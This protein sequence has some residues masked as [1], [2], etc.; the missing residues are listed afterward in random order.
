M[1]D[2]A[3]ARRSPRPSLPQYFGAA[4]ARGAAL[5]E[6]MAWT[7]NHARGARRDDA[8]SSSDESP[9]PMDRMFGTEVGR[10]AANRIGNETRTLAA[11]QRLS[12]EI[13]A[14]ALRETRQVRKGDRLLAM[15]GRDDRAPVLLL[16]SSTLEDVDSSRVVSG[17][18]DLPLNVLMRGLERAA[19]SAGESAEAVAFRELL[20]GGREAVA[21]L[22]LVAQPEVVL[23][24]RPRMIRLCVPVPH[25]SV[26]ARGEL[27]TA[28][29]LCRDSDGELGVTACFH[30][31]GPAGTPVRVGDEESHVKRASEVQDIVFIPLGDPFP[32]APMHGIAG[33]R[34]DREPARA[35]T[36][37]FD[38]AVNQNRRT[39][40]F[41]TDTGLLRA[42]PT[43]M[44]KLQTDPDTD[45]GD[46]GCAL[47][48]D[49]D[50]VLGFAFERTAYD[51]YPQF[52]DWIWAANALRALDLAPFTGT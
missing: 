25:V 43:I 9:H 46:S 41:S 42:R 17:E 35:D 3:L 2:M 23:T 51:D 32:F 12:V 45:Q 30:G 5:D 20:E 24:R 8:L 31:T 39:R 33:V 49:G 6:Q 19:D 10:R 52:T 27:S 18:L 34:D 44:L 14:A 7:V 36:V 16:M 15:P 11:L 40:I 48:D 50:R 47:L 28:G 26:E 21:E 4:G 29:V 37:R 13:V 22:F 38:G 1:L